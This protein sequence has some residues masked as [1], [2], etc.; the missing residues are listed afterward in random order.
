M[1]LR[2]WP[3][4]AGAASRLAEARLV[5]ETGSQGVQDARDIA[6]QALMREPINVVAARV[7]G[8]T[9]GLE[10]NE[11]QSRRLLNYAEMLSRRD[12]PT[13]IAQ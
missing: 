13:Q 5:S 4:A 2:M 1:A 7:V 10:G 3:F 9:A 6:T 12:I 11:K 8:L